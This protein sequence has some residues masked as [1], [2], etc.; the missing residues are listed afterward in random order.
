MNI[1]DNYLQA[2]QTQDKVRRNTRERE[3]VDTDCESIIEGRM[4]LLGDFNAHRPDWNV[5]W[6]TRRAVK[7]HKELVK[8]H[9]LIMNNGP[10]KATWRNK[11]K[12]ISINDLTLTTAKVGMLDT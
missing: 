1:Y 12:T 11:R 4:I 3:L 5:H 9:D 8:S 6:G 7:W 2:D 10:G